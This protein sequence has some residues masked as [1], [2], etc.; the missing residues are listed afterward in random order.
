M[1]PITI[2]NRAAIKNLSSRETDGFTSKFDQTSKERI[3]P[4]LHELL[5]GRGRGGAPTGTILMPTPP[6]IDRMEATS[7]LGK[8][9]QKPKVGTGRS[10]ATWY[11]KMRHMA[12]LGF[13]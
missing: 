13:F 7:P 5:Q 8:N 1:N 6:N 3:V 11:K 10:N 12:S 4:F 2:K 9:V